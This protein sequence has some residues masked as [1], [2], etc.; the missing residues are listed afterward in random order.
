MQEVSWGVFGE[1]QRGTRSGLCRRTSGCGTRLQQRLSRSHRELGSCRGP[2]EVSLIELG[3]STSVPQH[4]PVS[5]VPQVALGMGCT[6]RC[7]SSLWPG[8]FPGGTQLGVSA[9]SP[10]RACRSGC[11]IPVGG[12]GQHTTATTISSG[13]H[14]LKNKE[15]ECRALSLTT[16]LLCDLGHIVSLG[17]S[18]PICTLRRCY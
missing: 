3:S 12:S 2:S 11:P 9:A 4:P 13:K 7:S 8:K 1:Q 10:L 18:F 14:K 16:D 6:L 17:L 15:K 5:T